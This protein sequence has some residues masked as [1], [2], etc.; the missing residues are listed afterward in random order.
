MSFEQME[1]KQPDLDLK[2]SICDNMCTIIS[3]KQT[4]QYMTNGNSSTNH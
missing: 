2:K 1:V 4:P 3:R